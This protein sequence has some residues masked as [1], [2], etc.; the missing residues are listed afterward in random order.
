MARLLVTCL[1]RLPV[2]L[3][4]RLGRW[5]GWLAWRAMPSRRLVVRRNLETVNRW[6][7]ED[8][9]KLPLES[10]VKEVFQRAG[11][12]LLSGFTFIRMFPEQ[13]AR[14]IEFTGVSHLQAAL[15][16][17]R[18][19]IV[20]LAHMGPWEALTQLSALARTE[21]ID[22]PFGAMYRPL[23]NAYLDEWFRTQRAASGAQL[24][25]RLDGFHKPVDFLRGGGMLGI[26]ADQKMREGPSVSYFGEVVPTSPVAGLFKRRSGAPLVVVSFETIGPVRWRLTILPVEWPES[27]ASKDRETPAR[28]C[29]AALEAA[30]GRQPLDGFWLHKRFR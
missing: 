10:Q 13:A 28:C 23:N 1:Q 16:Q 4:F 9:P 12:N 19:V 15:A 5:L 24:F 3:A 29:N 22:A 18:G 7:A 21:G 6:L 11:A 8:A 25:S 30:L 2:G 17:G 20:L 26:L 27:L 14:H